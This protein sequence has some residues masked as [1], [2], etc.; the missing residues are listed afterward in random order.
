MT[1]AIE[2]DD[3]EVRY[4]PRVALRGVT[5]SLPK[6]R[7]GLVG[8]SGAGKSS[9]LKALLGKITSLSV[10]IEPLVVLTGVLVGLVSGVLGAL[11]PGMRAAMLDPVEALNYE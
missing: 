5:L 8:P 6:G 3:V 2:L 9:L 10:T 4:G 11:Y 7:I 1:L